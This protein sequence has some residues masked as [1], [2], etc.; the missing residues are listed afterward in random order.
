MGDP[1]V[2]FEWGDVIAPCSGHHEE[3][4][5]IEPY[6]PLHFFWIPYLTKTIYIDIPL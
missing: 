6:N 2:S 1:S 4:L 5:P 3:V